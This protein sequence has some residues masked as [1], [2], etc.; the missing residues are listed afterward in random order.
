MRKRYWAQLSLP[1]LDMRPICPL[2]GNPTSLLGQWSPFRPDACCKTCSQA[3][4]FPTDA[5]PALEQVRALSRASEPIRA[6]LRQ[7]VIDAGE[8]RA[9]IE[10][11]FRAAKAVQRAKYEMKDWNAMIAFRARQR[12]DFLRQAP[13][14]VCDQCGGSNTS[15]ISICQHCRDMDFVEWFLKMAPHTHPG[16]DDETLIDV[17]Y[18][19]VPLLFDTGEMPDLFYRLRYPQLAHE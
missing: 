1:G 10:A 9:Q 4:P 19:H 14:P 13:L 5:L 2:C 11:Q 8:L 18:K 15:G 3:H 16:A 12:A 17:L 6:D 7:I